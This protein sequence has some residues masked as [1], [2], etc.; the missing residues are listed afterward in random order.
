MKRIIGLSAFLFCLSAPELVAATLTGRVLDPSTS[1]IP[2]AMLCLTNIDTNQAL[3]AQ[4][5]SRGIYTFPSVPGGR[6]SLSAQAPGFE[7]LVQG[8]LEVRDRESLSVDINLKIRAMAEQVSVSA[9]APNFTTAL[10]GRDVKESPARDVGEALTSVEGL[11]KVRKGGIANDVVLRGL[12]G[13]NLNVLVDGAR[14]FGACPSHMDPPAF[15]VDFAEVQDVVVTKGAFD[16]KNEGSLGGSVQVVNKEAARGFHVLPSLSTGSF[17]FINP[18]LTGSI[19]EGKYSALIGYSYRRSD[20]YTDGNGKPFTAYTNYRASDQGRSAFDIQTGWGKFEFSPWE[21][22]RLELGYTRQAGDGVLYPYLMMDS[23]YDNADRVK[24]AYDINNLSGAFKD[25]HFLTYF[26][27]VHHDMTDEFR[28]SSV[29]APRP[30]SMAALAKT[31][32][33]G[34]RVDAELSDFSI[35]MEVFRRDWNLLDTML[36]MG[37]YMTQNAIPNVQ[38]TIAGAY[39]EYRRT[40][41]Q[42]LHFQAGGRLDTARSEARGQSLDTSLYWAYNGTRTTSSANTNPAGNLQ[43]AYS[44][45][46]GF[47]FFGGVGRT[48]RLPDPA[49]RYLALTGMGSEWVGNPLLRPTENS[50]VDVGINYAGRRF[51]V[52]P[53]LFY[54]RLTDFI[55]IH[56]QSQM[57]ALMGVMNAMARSYANVDARL[58]GG[59]LTYSL[60]ITRSLLLLGGTSYTVGTSAPKPEDNIFSTNLAEIPPLKSRAVLRYGTKRFFGEVEGIAVD[61]QNRVDTELGETRTP[62]YFTMGLKA[63]WHGKKLNLAGGIDN[64][65]DRFY[66]EYLSFQRDPFR[67]GIRVPEPGRNVY[68]S[69]S[70]AF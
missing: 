37:D 47:S 70:Y 18:S 35:G 3:T 42:K 65:L 32:A 63:G 51:Q 33:L 54:S 15:H 41:F 31:Q 14:I 27:Q 66:Y 9:K 16:V 58:Y 62:G 43:L 46:R 11:W 36:M 53:T 8:A 25:L 55:T 40:F 52:R 20:P 1:L 22:Q 68:L 7:K 10:E 61:A 60:G 57:N 44:L 45:G 34:L 28:T 6:Y 38:M 19:S 49:E 17:G 67:S 23:P 13:G 12:Q 48:V 56:N 21:K 64:L 26:T 39:G 5:D 29:G 4:S 59:E 24:V 69:F 2:G 30:Y 50:E